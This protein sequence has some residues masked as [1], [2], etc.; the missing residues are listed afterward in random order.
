MRGGEGA[1][2]CPAPKAAIRVHGSFQHREPDRREAERKSSRR[3]R[4]V[5]SRCGGVALSRRRPFGGEDEDLSRRQYGALGPAWLWVV[6]AANERRGIR[7]TS[8]HPA[9]PGG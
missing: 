6:G 9:H 3:P 1:S 7:R 2:S 8:G 4:R 5:A